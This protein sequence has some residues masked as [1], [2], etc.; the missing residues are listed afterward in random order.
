MPIYMDRHDVSD[1]V[2]AEIVAHIHLEDLKIQHHYNCK[3]LTYWFDEERKIAFCLVDSPNKQAIVDMHNNAH[4]EIPHQIVEVDTA[5]V[6]SFLG[7]IED[8]VKISNTSLNIISDPAFRT[9]M[10]INLQQKSF[11]NITSNPSS[12][13]AESQNHNIREVIGPYNGRVVKSLDNYF[14]VSFESTTESVLCAKEIHKQFNEN[15]IYDVKIG[16]HAGVPITEK[17]SLFEETILFAKRLCIISRANILL[18]NEVKM[19]FEMENPN[20]DLKK[21]PILFLTPKNETFLNRFFDFIE[22]NWQNADLKVNDFNRGLGYSKANMYR[23]MK[24]ITSLSPNIFLMDYRL[25][26]A[27]ALF[28]QQTGNV[29][30]IAFQTGFNDPSYF[31]KC[32]LKKFKVSPSDYLRSRLL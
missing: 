13:Q 20:I 1:T 28:N 5:V 4:G 31:S 30:E 7:R 12:L 2:T 22:N 18:S 24:L 6:E 26:Q 11:V 9:L 21:M 15:L 16:L 3:G 8:P 25:N 32:F 29:S 17:D 14:L 19:L 23:K 10:V 27:L